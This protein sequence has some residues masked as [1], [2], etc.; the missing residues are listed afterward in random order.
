M[1]GMTFGA[2]S[3]G[4]LMKIG[5][6]KSLL[7]VIAISIAGSLVIFHLNF[8]LLLI[9][10]LLFGF[11]AGLF[12]SII[13]KFLVE[14]SP[15]N[16][17]ELVGVSFSFAQTIGTLFGFLMGEFMPA[18]DDTAGLEQTNNW[19]ISYIYFPVALN[20][21]TLLALFLVVKYDTI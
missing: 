8:T 3:G 19:R 2:V 13:P 9:S 21:L 11:S 1:I 12:T 4:L 14:T 10:R 15:A 6:R 16:Y 20:L 17:Y 7:I 18:D 5:R